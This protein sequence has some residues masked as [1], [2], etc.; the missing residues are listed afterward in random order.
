M[1]LWILHAKKHNEGEEEKGRTGR[2]DLHFPKANYIDMKLWGVM[3]YTICNG[4]I[5]AANSIVKVTVGGN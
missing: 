5:N 4:R 1:S 2:Y 3:D